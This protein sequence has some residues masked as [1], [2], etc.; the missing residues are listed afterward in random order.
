MQ[1]SC[2]STV[3]PNQNPREGR[4]ER[5]TAP[6][7]MVPGPG[8][9]RTGGP[10]LN[11]ITDLLGGDGVVFDGR[12]KGPPITGLHPEDDAF[13]EAGEE[14][15][16]DGPKGAGKGKF[17]NEGGFKYFGHGILLTEQLG[18]SAPT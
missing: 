6:G 7:F 12:D 9:D 11:E 4:V 2:I 3:E 13:A 10:D 8:G 18:P 17:E 16:L 1:Q 15:A 5:L 14:R